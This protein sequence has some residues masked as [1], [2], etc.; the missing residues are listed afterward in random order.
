MKPARHVTRREIPRTILAGLLALFA[1]TV[2]V[3]APARADDD[4]PPRIGRVAEMTGEL[5]LAPEDAAD[6]WVAIGVNYPVATG[7]NLWVGNEGR[8]EIDFGGGQLRLAG[9]TS[10]HVSRLDDRNLALFVAQG[11]VI[12]RIRVL[13]PGEAARIDTPN[14]QIALSRPGLYRI[15]VTEDHQH[16]QVAV[17]EGEAIIDTGAAVQQVLPGQS[18]SLDGAAPQY[19]QMRSGVTTDGFDTWSANR[20]RRYERSRA[21]SPVSRQMVGA[22][23]LDEYG[24]WET[25][26]E[27]GAVW[28]PA[29]VA[30]DWAPYR[31]GYWT[32]VAVWGP[33]WV[34]AA[35]W[36]YAPF[37]YGRW[38]HFRGRWGW[39][40]GA[41]VA[42]PVWAPALVGWIGGPGWRVS[43]NH[44]APV[45]GWVPLGWGE[46]Y[47]PHWRGCSEGCWVRYNK[48]YAV[49]T[50]VRPSVPPARWANSS[51]PGAVTV[52]PGSTFAGRKPVAPNL[53]AISGSAVASAP[54]LAAPTI[55]PEIRQTPGIRPG[56]GVPPPASSTVW[57]RQPRIVAP[58]GPAPNQGSTAAAPT[59]SRTPPVVSTPA[60][61]APG[62]PPSV[63]K[64]LQGPT[65]PQVST[66]TFPAPRPQP[67]LVNPP[68]SS[69][70]VAVSPTGG[71]P[72]SRNQP[73]PQPGAAA[74]VAVPSGFAGQ[75]GVALPKPVPA[76]VPIREPRAVPTLPVPTAPTQTPLP[77]PQSAH[78]APIVP[79]PRTVPGAPV[80]VP[81]TAHPG[82]V[83]KVEKPVQPPV[84]A[85]V[86]VPA[87]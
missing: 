67:V 82:E 74:P 52:V 20:D 23:D 50:T 3:P 63:A 32:D 1:L 44:G 75:G 86:D 45:Y 39:C 12:L 22:A 14:V 41:Y 56:N 8:A 40:P 58:A 59:V 46:A 10:L 24:A 21:N 7:D 87:K 81:P 15:E 25:A 43:T 54:V 17:R 79:A 4:L 36:G 57:M 80:A 78:Q 64:P 35:P 60:N 55:R 53:V 2:L 49:N 51:A 18:A 83:A 66:N 76:P 13:D 5:F 16:T 47:Q 42:R 72:K 19:A 9:D 85:P 26:P 48:P 11:R 77:S 38:V 33:T 34:D 62:A 28:Y 84:K 30:E 6:Q 65:T 37:H 61:S 73:L 27:Y 29:N 70:P 71:E 69:N 31:N 68:A